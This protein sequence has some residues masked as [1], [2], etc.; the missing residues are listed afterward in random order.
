MSKGH[1]I[2]YS[3]AKI[4]WALFFLTVIEVAW[5]MFFREPRWF[6][7]SG[8]LLCALL[9]GLLIFMYFMHMKFE[10]WILW[11]LVVPTVPLM[12]VVV[13]ALMP[14]LSFNTWREHP[15]GNQLDAQ[16]RV[17]RMI[18]LPSQPPGA[19]AAPADGEEH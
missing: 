2:G 11:A 15:V 12:A 13:F 4:F 17:V 16:G 9:K 10:R 19:A 8:L 18:D 3:I 14:D 7:W 1:D 5:G 6:L